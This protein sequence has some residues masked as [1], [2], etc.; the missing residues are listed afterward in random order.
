MHQE[1]LSIACKLYQSAVAGTVPV[2]SCE[3]A[4]AAKVLENIY[5]AVNIAL[6]NELKVL[7]RRDGDR[8]VAGS[9]QRSENQAVWFSS[10][11]S[12]SRT[13][14]TLY[15]DRSVLSFMARP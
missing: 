3:V 11:L 10:I 5:R 13:G 8:T 4:E 12:R 9:N 1:S 14:W 6:V 7:F 15:P 2:S